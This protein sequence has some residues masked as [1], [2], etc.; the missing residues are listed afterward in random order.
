M[1]NFQWRGV[2]G[3]DGGL[4]LVP[5]TEFPGGYGSTPSTL[6]IPSTLY[7]GDN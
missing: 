6:S 2:E 5:F 4:Y 1:G 3:L 7:K